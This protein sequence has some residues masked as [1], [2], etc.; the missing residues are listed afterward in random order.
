MTPAASHKVLVV[1]DAGLFLE[2]GAGAAGL[3]N[4]RSASGT[5]IELV[6]IQR[7]RP[8][9]G[10]RSNL[11]GRGGGGRVEK[12]EGHNGGN[13]LIAELHGFGYR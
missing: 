2:R 7:V 10:A 9:D 13:R 12:H 5:F 8:S 6:A 4:R 11:G 1:T 3:V